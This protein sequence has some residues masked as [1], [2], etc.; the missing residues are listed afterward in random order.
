ME[1]TTPTPL[2]VTKSRVLPES[3]PKDN[4]GRTDQ[5]SSGFREKEFLLPVQTREAYVGSRTGLPGTVTGLF[6][7]TLHDGGKGNVG[8]GNRLVNLSQKGVKGGGG[9]CV[10]GCLTTEVKPPYST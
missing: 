7:S 5:G 6:D 2:L 4:D 9:V 1:R 8:H 3:D 10:Q